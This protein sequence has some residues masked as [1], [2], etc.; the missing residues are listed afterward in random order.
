MFSIDFGNL[1]KRFIP[2]FLRDKIVAWMESLVKPLTTLNQTMVYPWRLRM[3]NY[4]SYDGM[5]V[6]L[7]RYLNLVY[8]TITD[9]N[10]NIRNNQIA[11]V[12]IIYIETTANN[13]FRYVYNKAENNPPIYLYNNAE[14]AAPEYFYNV[15]EQGTFPAFTVWIPTALG[16][17]Y[18]TAGTEDNIQLRGKVDMFRLAGNTN[19]LIKRY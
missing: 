4:L 18:E 3:I 15:S 5:T 11:A 14:A 13:A 17:T 9:Y 12:E 10:P 8:N 19:Y 2:W 16:G 1:I 7:E 6:H